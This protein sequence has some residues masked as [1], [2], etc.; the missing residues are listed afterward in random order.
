MVNGECRRTSLNRTF[1]RAK[2][3]VDVVL[4]AAALV[5]L[6]P[7]VAGAALAVRAALGPGVL[8]RQPR[9]GLH[10][11][12]F[13]VLKFRTMLDPDPARGRV[14]DAQRM[15]RLGDLLRAT[16]LDELP[17]LVNVLRGDMSLVG[18]RPLRMRYLERYSED[19]AHRHDVLPGVTGLAQVSGRNA[20]SWDDRFDL[21]LQYVRDQGPLTDL[22]ILLATVPAVLH[23]RGIREAGHATMSDFYGPHRIGEHE[24][25]TATD[26]TGGARWEVVE[27]A[28]CSVVARCH[29]ER[30]ESGTARQRV[31]V[32]VRGPGQGVVRDRAV[33]MMLSVAREQGAEEVLL[34][35]RGATGRG[36]P[37]RLGLHPVAPCRDGDETATV[38]GERL[39]R[40]LAQEGR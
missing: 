4:S 1:Y 40:D 9:P 12:E 10:G 7:V 19:Q 18:P 14:T 5:L 21:D 22:R 13:E 27:R 39:R 26:G 28:D 38:R 37:G 11:Q 6:S 34:D 25:R 3:T 15:T 24:L 36:L 30:G 31:E 16:S 23:R 8:F 35:L 20:L 33:E 32:L 29:S 2:R 17:G